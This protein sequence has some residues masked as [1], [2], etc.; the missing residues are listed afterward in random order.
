MN[1][2]QPQFLCIGAQKA[3]TTWL[4]KCLSLHP[5]IWLHPYK[6]IHYFD[7]V[8]LQAK[9]RE[10]RIKNLHK[11]LT[12]VV[13]QGEQTEKLSEL[14]LLSEL[15]LVDQYTDSWYLSLFR[16]ADKNQMI[17][18][19]TPAYSAL[20]EQG[21]KHIKDLL[22]DIK[23]IFIMRNPVKRAWSAALMSKRQQIIKG[24][25]ISDKDWIRYF[26]NRKDYKQ[27]S[28]YKRTIETYEKYFN[29]ILYLFYDDVCENTTLLLKKVCNFLDVDPNIKVFDNIYREKFNV[30]PQLTISLSVESYLR[31]EF[32]TLE[33]WIIER[34][35]PDRFEL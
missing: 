18:E 1:Q 21:V 6:E 17:G 23:I 12:K 28:D 2:P 11:R 27:R 35:N 19:I 25:T 26:Q 15:A 7:V 32:S 5:E 14:K 20:P 8:H 24:D 4:H 16:D 31:E 30:N 22:G 33:E 13:Q 34:F 3:G 29:K 10:K 9:F